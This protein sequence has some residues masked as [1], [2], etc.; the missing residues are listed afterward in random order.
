[1]SCFYKK[2]KKRKCII[3]THK[4]TKLDIEESVL[5]GKTCLRGT[6]NISGPEGKYKVNKYI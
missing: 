2:H 5:I 4:P 1:M 6:T 3:Y